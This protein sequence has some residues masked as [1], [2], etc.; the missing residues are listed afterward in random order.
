MSRRAFPF[1]AVLFGWSA[2]ANLFAISGKAGR[3]FAIACPIGNAAN[4]ADAHDEV[5]R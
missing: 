1:I 4:C 5:A 2:A 3:R